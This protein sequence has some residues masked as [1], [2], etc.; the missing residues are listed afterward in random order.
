MTLVTKRAHDSKGEKN[1]PPPLEE[2]TKKQKRTKEKKTANLSR[3]IKT[4]VSVDNK[5]R[6]LAMESKLKIT[7]YSLVNAKL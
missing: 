5:K 3:N 2:Q 7:L 4:G 1:Y 6:I